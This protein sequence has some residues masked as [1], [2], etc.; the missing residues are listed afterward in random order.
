MACA[1]VITTDVA[2]QDELSLNRFYVS[3]QFAKFEVGKS[4]TDL[5]TIHIGAN[6]EEIRT[7]SAFN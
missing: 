3:T 6:L 7:T 2:L 4:I 5:D 1:Y